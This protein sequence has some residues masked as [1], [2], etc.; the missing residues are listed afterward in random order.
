MIT[1]LAK[2][3]KLSAPAVGAKSVRLKWRAAAGARRYEIQRDGKRIGSTAARSFTDP[4]PK[5]GAKHRYRVRALGKH[6]LVGPWSSTIAVKVPRA[7]TDP[8]PQPVPDNPDPNNP[9]ATTGGGPTTDPGPGPGAGI[10]GNPV[11][12]RAMVDRMFWRAG[13]GPT[14]AERSAWTGKKH[15]EVVDFLL[16]HAQALT[17]TSTPPV[18]D[19]NQPIDPLV[20]D[21]ELVMEWLD[22][23]MR[24]ENPLTERLTL[25][26][27]RHWAVSRDNGIP[28]QSMLDYRDRLRRF[29]DLAQFPHASF[30]QLALEMTTQDAAM[31][32]WLDSWRNQKGNPNENYAREFMELFSLGVLDDNGDPN[33]TQSDVMEL[34]RAFTGWR[35]DQQPGSPTY[36]QVSFGG[37]NYFDAGNKTVFGQTAKWGAVAGNPAGTQ[38]A[39]DLILSRPIHPH[40]LIRKMWGE[41]IAAPIPAAALDD[42]AAAYTAGGALE[43]K[44]IVQGILSHPLIFESIDEPNLV[45]PPVVYTVG[46]QR[47]MGGPLKSYHQAGMLDLMQQHPYRPPNVAGWEGGLSWLNTNTAWARFQLIKESQWVK[48]A[49]YPGAQ[50][51]ADVAGETAD[52]AFDRALA[53]V[54]SPWMSPNT[55][56]MLRQFSA[57][58]PAGTATQRAHRQYALRALILA[59]PDGQ[60]M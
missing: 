29:A 28:A 31:S 10:G 36:G 34:A 42:L 40:F 14:D 5:P 25:Y 53:A 59:G 49:G 51:V 12:T 38:S 45:K 33:Y 56:T 7:L 15:L 48:H 3:V 23:M 4:K 44:P 50:G 43:I 22:T 6:G 2:V 54:S 41:F 37:T 39:V 18:T 35:L 30:R 1:K 58:Q 55:E 9:G 47:M 8:G 21:N 60:V 57:A 13:F 52:A 27:H 20:S 32:Y 17:P 16:T 24:A 46:V 19:S 11:L 26:W